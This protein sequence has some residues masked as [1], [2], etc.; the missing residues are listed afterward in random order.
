MFKNKTVKCYCG[1]RKGRGEFCLLSWEVGGHMYILKEL[2][3]ELSC[4]NVLCITIENKILQ[5]L[6]IKHSECN[7]CQYIRSRNVFIT[8]RS[9]LSIKKLLK[10]FQTA[11]SKNNNNTRSSIRKAQELY[12]D[13]GVFVNDSSQQHPNLALNRGRYCWQKKSQKQIIFLR[14]DSY[15]CDFFKKSGILLLTSFRNVN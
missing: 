14:I 12:L 3:I 1:Y 5:M 15:F 2:I 13:S 8:L 9:S 10:L 4:R 6:K 7:I 11:R